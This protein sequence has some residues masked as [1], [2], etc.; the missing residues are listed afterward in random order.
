ME[1]RHARRT[2]CC[3]HGHLKPAK[4]LTKDGSVE[5]DPPEVTF[6]CRQL[7][8]HARASEDA[9]LPSCGG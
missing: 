6:P 3:C 8:I 2:F 7:S 5:A 9:L 1:R 4:G